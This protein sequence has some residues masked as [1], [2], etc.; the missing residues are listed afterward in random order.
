[1]SD[2]PLPCVPPST[3][4]FDPQ[5]L[6]RITATIEA[7][8]AAKRLPGAVILIARRGALAFAEAYGY[9]D[10]A[11]GIG[12]TLD[13]I[14]RIFS[15]TKPVTAV[16]TLLLAEEGRL[17]LAQPVQEILPGFSPV[18]VCMPHGRTDEVDH[19]PLIPP[20]RG[21][22]VH[23]LLTHCAG[24]PYGAWSDS[25]GVREAH[26]RLNLGVNPRDLEPGDF[27]RRLSAAPLAQQPG[28]VWQYGLASDVLGLVVEQV[29][30]ERLGT[31]LR[32][33]LF[34]PL[35]MSDTGFSVSPAMRSRVAEPFPADPLTGLRLRQPDQ[36]FDAVAVP[37]MDAG[38]AGAV[39]TA[40]DY[41]RFANMLLQQGRHNGANILSPA[42]VRLMTSDHLGVRA[43][44]A[45]TPGE[46]AM[47]SPGYGFGFG[48]AVRL[49]DGDAAVPGSAGD[50]F[51]SGTAGTVFWVDPRE[52]L[53]VVF[54]TQAP[55]AMRLRY[56]RLAR[57]LVYQAIVS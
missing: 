30:G 16:A 53:A 56:R 19:D 25:K 55:G 2:L 27:L 22:T 7:D 37:Q 34:A 50:F 52:Q 4:G 28:R 39:S 32:S 11:R 31:F 10:S 46:A 6:K 49:A 41:L 24:L 45:P 15:M 40:G 48:V 42:M 13:S 26:A 5:R 36:T 20:V 38:G 21:V 43:A 1:M 44:V 14:F 47:Q 35:G 8:V 33:R 23:D 54:M 29:A 18:S 3:V 9:R 51:W 17:Q 57:Q 12:M